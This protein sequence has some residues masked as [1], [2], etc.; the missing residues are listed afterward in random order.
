MS[1][2][3]AAMAPRGPFPGSIRCSLRSA[4]APQ[5][6]PRR[7]EN[8]TTRLGCRFIDVIM[9]DAWYLSIIELRFDVE[10][11]HDLELEKLSEV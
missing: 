8:S 7:T 9:L 3:K 4:P 10:G 11:L 1:P 2:Q 6:T 5:G